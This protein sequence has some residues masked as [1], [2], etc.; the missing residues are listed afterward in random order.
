MA[1]RVRLGVEFGLRMVF[2]LVCVGSVRQFVVDFANGEGRE[3]KL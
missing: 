3:L 1:L 2:A